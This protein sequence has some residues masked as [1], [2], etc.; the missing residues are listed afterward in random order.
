MDFWR[1]SWHCKQWTSTYLFCTNSRLRHPTGP[2]KI[3]FDVPISVRAGTER[4]ALRDA[5]V[6]PVSMGEL[7]VTCHCWD[8]WKWPVHQRAGQWSQASCFFQPWILPSLP[9]CWESEL[10]VLWAAG[11]GFSGN[12]L[13]GLLGT[14]FRLWCLSYIKRCLSVVIWLIIIAGPNSQR[15]SVPACSTL[16]ASSL[17]ELWG[18]KCNLSR[19]THLSPKHY[20]K[21]DDAKAATSPL[22][23]VMHL[24]LTLLVS[25]FGVHGTFHDG[26]CTSEVGMILGRLGRRWLY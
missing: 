9:R 15:C 21:I 7:F 13:L 19:V 20:V 14:A 2:W 16:H 22:L 25:P 12:A 23:N 18:G 5:L 4:C 8:E 17:M 1:Q 10:A 11:H 6:P 26:V 24:R 3:D